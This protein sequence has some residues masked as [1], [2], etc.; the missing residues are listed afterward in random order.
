MDYFKS[1]NETISDFE[2]HYHD[3]LNELERDLN[4]ITDLYLFL[5]SKKPEYCLKEKASCLLDE[6]SL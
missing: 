4:K 6:K 3:E 5:L 2:K 1:R